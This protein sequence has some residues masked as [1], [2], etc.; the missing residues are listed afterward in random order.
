MVINR[1]YI[2]TL[3][4]ITTTYLG[5]TQEYKQECIQEAYNIGDKQNYQTNVKAFM[6]SYRIW[7]ETDVYNDLLHRIQDEISTK[8]NLIYTKN[9]EYELKNAWTAIYKEGHYT[10]PHDHIPSQISFVYYLK[11]NTNSSPLLF[12]GDNFQVNTNDD[13]L[14]TFPSHLLHRVSKHKGEDRICLAGNLNYKPTKT[15]NKLSDGNS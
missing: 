6:S 15:N 12:E 1:H 10:L 7:E 3:S 8:L 2:K 4:E 14:V 11:S 9:F 5:I 13:L